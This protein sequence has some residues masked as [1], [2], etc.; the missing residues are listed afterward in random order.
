MNHRPRVYE[1]REIPTSPRRVIAADLPALRWA[2]TLRSY[3]Q[4]IA[5]CEAPYC[6]TRRFSR[7]YRT[8]IPWKRSRLKGQ[9]GIRTR[10]GRPRIPVTLRN[11]LRLLFS[12]ETRFGGFVLPTSGS[13][14]FETIRALCL[15]LRQSW[16]P[17]DGC[18]HAVSEAEFSGPAGCRP[19][20][21]GFVPIFSRSLR[22]SYRISFSS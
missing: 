11:P 22:S 16:Q 2:L 21:S 5:L 7:T 17:S 18:A 13:Q 14:P 1:T 9:L 15:P 6:P 12:A 20:R 4:R 19:R 3:E 10:D 8:F